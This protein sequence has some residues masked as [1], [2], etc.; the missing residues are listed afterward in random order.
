MAAV[1]S[2]VKAEFSRQ[3]ASW[4]EEFKHDF[5]S[6][7]LEQLS[8]R[9]L[10]KRLHPV[11]RTTTS[12]RAAKQATPVC[13]LQRHYNRLWRLLCPVIEQ[14]NAGNARAKRDLLIALRVVE[15]YEGTQGWTKS[16]YDPCFCQGTVHSTPPGCCTGAT[17][18]VSLLTGAA[19]CQGC[20]VVVAPQPRAP[21][22]SCRGRESTAV[23]Y[24]TWC[25]SQP[26]SPR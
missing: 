23:T 4:C 10:C 5:S 2:I 17:R 12:G 9:Y 18:A 21:A 15:R 6:R 26:W 3:A 24:T 7:Q 19:G 16:A 22:R 14:A 8:S 11:V 20:F 13:S 25:N 1:Q